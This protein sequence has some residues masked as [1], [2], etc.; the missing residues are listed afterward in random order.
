MHSVSCKVMRNVFCT[1]LYLLSTSQ[2][3][4]LRRS[5][6]ILTLLV[7]LL[8]PWGSSV[9]PREITAVF[10]EGK[11]FLPLYFKH[12]ASLSLYELHISLQPYIHC[13]ASLTS[14]QALPLFMNPLY[15]L[16]TDSL[17]AGLAEWNVV[18]SAWVVA[19]FYSSR[20]IRQ[21]QRNAF[22]H[23]LQNILS[24]FFSSIKCF[25][26]IING[27]Q[28]QLT[29]ACFLQIIAKQTKA[30]RNSREGFMQG[31]N[32]NTRKKTHLA[33]YDIHSHPSVPLLQETAPS[34]RLAQF[35][36]RL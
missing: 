2:S 7:P 3:P 13:P 31:H 6:A 23:L 36:V 11:R 1:N 14:R 27:P 10:S 24:I 15:H 26:F 30:V 5:E 35:F 34:E 21:A 29:S 28:R 25:I 18:R 33:M 32:M 9:S 8:P 20:T 17:T 22:S 16:L 19:A 12:A 4:L